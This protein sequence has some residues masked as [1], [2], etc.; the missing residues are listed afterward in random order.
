MK[1]VTVVRDD[2]TSKKV[3]ETIKSSLKITYDNDNPDYV[4]A[5]GGDGTIIKASHQYPDAI[6]FG[7]HTGHL[8]FYA[9]YTLDDI[10]VLINDINNNDFKVSN[11]DKISIFVN[12]GKEEKLFGSALNEI[13]IN[14]PLSAIAMDVSIDD[15]FFERFKGTGLCFSTPYGSTAYNKSLNGAVL[16]TSLNLIQMTEIA[17]INSNAYRTLA[18]PL[19]LDGRRIIK[20]DKFKNINK[21]YITIDY[22]TH[23]MNNLE[24]ISVLSNGLST[25]MAYH[26]YEDHLNR[27]KRTFL[28]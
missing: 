22:E 9:N 25:K 8:G 23:E 17:G 11:V 26:E 12:D 14:T 6:I 18:S 21:L 1:Y 5:I 24:S 27:I 7:I 19:V 28:K 2:N 3:E 15:N 16:D 13:T 4:I 10:N 20:L